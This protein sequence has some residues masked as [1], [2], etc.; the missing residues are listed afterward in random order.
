METMG[1]QVVDTRFRVK[2]IRTRLPCAYVCVP[3]CVCVCV[4]SVCCVYVTFMMCTLHVW[5]VFC[6]VCCALC[7][8]CVVY[9]GVCVC[10][11]YVVSDAVCSSKKL[12]LSTNPQS[13]RI[14]HPPLVLD[15]E[16]QVTSMIARHF[17]HIR[18]Q[19]ENKTSPFSRHTFCVTLDDGRCDAHCAAGP[20]G[21]G[22]YAVCRV[23]TVCVC[24][25]AMCGLS[26]RSGRGCT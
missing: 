11:F 2:V 18:K 16:I 24:V 10:V 23:G 22:G 17:Q 19:E 26:I 15:S 13:S 21:R 6:S 20:L 8:M 7:V 5:C 4:L 25:C 9:S 14:P 3:V 12:T 1:I